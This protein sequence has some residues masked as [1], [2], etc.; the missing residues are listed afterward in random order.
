LAEI[1]A[2][3]GLHKATAFRLL[4]TLCKRSIVMKDPSTGFYRLGL[5]LVEL[6]EIAKFSTGLVNLA[7]PIM[8]QIRDE[9]G[10]TVYI[11]ARVGDGRINVEQMDGLHDIRRVVTMGVF[12]PLY[13]GTT[14]RALLAGMPDDELQAYFSR[15]G[16][17]AKL[18]LKALAR[19]ITTSRRNGF[20]E[21]E[22]KEAEHGASI[23]AAICGYSNVVLG[24]LTVSTPLGRYTDDVRARTIDVVTTAARNLSRQLGAPAPAEPRVMKRPALR[25]GS[26]MPAAGERH[27]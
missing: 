4:A 15:A 16:T 11:A 2:R 22:N 26:P 12:T 21:T 14:S 13:T 25:S 19:G 18:D 9:L 1:A 7:R 10:E 17:V 6:A 3:S 27:F 8:H 20:A 24:A 23:S 5:G